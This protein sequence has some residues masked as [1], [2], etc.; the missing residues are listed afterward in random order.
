MQSSA[1]SAS[2]ATANNSA[3]ADINN[4]RRFERGANALRRS[5]D[6]QCAGDDAAQIAQFF[7]ALRQRV[8]A[9]GRGHRRKRFEMHGLRGGIARQP[10]FFRGEAQQRREPSHRAAEQLV[11]HCQARF[12][13][14][15]GIR[16]AIQRVL[17]NIEIERR[18]IGRHE[19]VECGKDAL[20]VEI[21]ISAADQRIELGEPMQHQALKLRHDII[22]DAV[23]GLEMRKVAEHPAQR[24]AE[25]AVSVDRGF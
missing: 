19:R 20:E 11:E 1:R 24:V 5:F 9:P 21:S 13:R 18:K 16:I 15:R 25:L 14:H 3:I 4:G 22:A 2:T 6:L 17:A 8:I 10:R 23:G 7:P 12:A